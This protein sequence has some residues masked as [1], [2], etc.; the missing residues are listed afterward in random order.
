MCQHFQNTDGQY[1]GCTETGTEW[2]RERRDGGERR[3]ME[4]EKR[5][6]TRRTEEEEEGRISEKCGGE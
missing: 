3:S 6:E 2:P 4:G 5:L 1:R